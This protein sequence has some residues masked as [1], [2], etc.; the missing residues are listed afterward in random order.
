[1]SVLCTLLLKGLVMVVLGLP[2]GMWQHVVVGTLGALGL[3]R[4]AQALRAA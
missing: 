1:M 4:P 2:E 3:L